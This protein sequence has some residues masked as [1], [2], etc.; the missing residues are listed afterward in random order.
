M[1]SL[2]PSTI[3]VTAPSASPNKHRCPWC[4]VLHEGQYLLCDTDE[5]KA[6]QLK[7]RRSA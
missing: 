6:K 7:E 5:E 4:G 1:N 3:P 2:N